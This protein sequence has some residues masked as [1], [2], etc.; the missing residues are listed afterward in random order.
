MRLSGIFLHTK[1]SGMYTVHP[2]PCMYECIPCTLRTLQCVYFI[3]STGTRMCG[4][5]PVEVRATIR[6]WAFTFFPHI[7]I[8]AL[9]LKICAVVIREITVSA[10]NDFVLSHACRCSGDVGIFLLIWDCNLLILA[11]PMGMLENIPYVDEYGEPAS[12]NSR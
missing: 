6:D 8:T 3:F 4:H 5:T 12:A 7:P 9:L 1:C 10:F 2:I 11:P